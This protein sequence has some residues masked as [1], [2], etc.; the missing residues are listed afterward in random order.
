MRGYREELA[1]APMRENLAAALIRASGWTG[2]APLVDPMC[3]AGTI[4]IEAALM[5]RRIPPGLAR[6]SRV[7]R[8]YAFEKWPM[9]NAEIWKDEVNAARS[10]VLD[11]SPVS[12][13]ASDRD[14][15]ATEITRRNAE[16][17][18]V[19]EDLTISRQAVSAL[20]HVGDS[21]AVVVTPPYGKRVGDEAP[22][23]DLYARLGSVMREHYVGWGFAIISAST[24]LDRQL[25]LKLQTIART[26]NGGIPVRIAVAKV[27]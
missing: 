2:A 26:A 3:G 15:G 24:V 11:R 18:G 12:I 16:R 21:G 25:G 14:A 19:Q 27:S 8:N 5:A 4:A 17:A 22:L 20:K 10:L 7:P 9:H 23:R 13:F 6:A 1:K